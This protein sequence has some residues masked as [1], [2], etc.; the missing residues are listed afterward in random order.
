MARKRFST[1]LKE[2]LNKIPEDKKP[3]AARIADEIIFMHSTLEDL[4]KHIKEHGTVEEFKQ[5]KQEFLRESPALK[6]YNTT[7]QRYS[8]LTKQL[9][10]M[11]PKEQ[12]AQSASAIYDFIKEGGSL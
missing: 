7:I 9:S 12:Q 3:I 4:R 6:S 8:Q 1:E 2:I 11:L 10:D 5:G